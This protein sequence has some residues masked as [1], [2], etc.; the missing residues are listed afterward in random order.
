MYP[1]SVRARASG[2]C[3][4]AAA[5]RQK[6]RALEA[7]PHACRALT[8]L[9]CAVL[10]SGTEIHS[11]FDDLGFSKVSCT[12]A[13]MST[14]AGPGRRCGVA[15]EEEE[16]GTQKEGLSFAAAAASPCP[17]SGWDPGRWC[18]PV[19]LAHRRAV[20]AL[21]R[22]QAARRVDIV[23]AELARLELGEQLR[24]LA[25]EAERIDDLYLALG[26]DAR[27]EHPLRVH[28]PLTQLRASRTEGDAGGRRR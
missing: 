1:R 10:K 12:E 26:V 25:L 16:R 13:R 9:T 21:R 3:C 22:R 20:R 28:G 18:R 14:C 24:L 17:R 2:R 23:V 15:A 19:A 8:Q 4:G 5:W 11:K 6:A 7:Q 27:E